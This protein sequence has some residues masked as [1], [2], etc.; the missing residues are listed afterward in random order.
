MTKETEWYEDPNARP[1]AITPMTQKE[2]EWYE[3]YIKRR[4]AAPQEQ[5]REQ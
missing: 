2:R 3:D 4:P 1:S 5:D